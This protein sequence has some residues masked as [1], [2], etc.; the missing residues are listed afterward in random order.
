MDTPNVVKITYRRCLKFKKHP[1]KSLEVDPLGT[2]SSILH[3]VLYVED[4]RVYI[5]A[6][7]KEFGESKMMDIYHKQLIDDTFELKPQYKALWDR[8][9]GH[10]IHFPCFAED[11]WVQYVLSRIHDKFMWLMRPFNITKDVI[12]AV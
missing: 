12:R 7:I 9:F 11:E 6:N 8:H 4:D 1:Y 3:G 5:H 10:Y 2:F